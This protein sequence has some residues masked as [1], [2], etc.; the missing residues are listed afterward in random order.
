MEDL[1]D[2]LPA[3]GLRLIGAICGAAPL[4]HLVSVK[5]HGVLK[6]AHRL[7]IRANSILWLHAVHTKEFGPV[8]L[9]VYNALGASSSCW[10]PGEVLVMGVQWRRWWKRLVVVVVVVAAIGLEAATAGE[11]GA[12]AMGGRSTGRSGSRRSSTRMS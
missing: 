11:A 6:N 12:P 3:T 8:R 9:H 4:L 2:L 10:V 5:Q 7:F 1:P